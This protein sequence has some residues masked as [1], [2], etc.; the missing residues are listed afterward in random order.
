MTICVVGNSHTIALKEA[1]DGFPWAFSY[2]CAPGFNLT[3]VIVQDGKLVGGTENLKAILANWSALGVGN[4][5]QEVEL[6]A[7]SAFVVV[8]LGLS[9][10]HLARSYASVR[11][12]NHMNRGMTMVSVDCLEE[13][14][15]ARIRSTSAFKIARLLRENSDRPIIVVAQP[16]PLE[17]AKTVVSQGTQKRKRKSPWQILDDMNVSEILLPIYERALAKAAATENVIAIAQPAATM[18]GVRTKAEYQCKPDDYRHANKS[19]GAHMLGR[20]KS[21]LETVGL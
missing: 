18:T 19:Y 13:I 16:A 17:T 7:S 9:P 2:F 11:L 8:G 15:V 14:L 21:T 20:L 5:L 4:V 3:D 6:R 12:F 1:A 10:L